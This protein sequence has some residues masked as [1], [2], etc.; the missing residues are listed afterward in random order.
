MAAYRPKAK[1]LLGIDISATAIKLIELSRR[2]SGYRVESHA[3]V[4][5]SAGAVVDG[6]VVD[7]EA[8]GNA[9]R[10]AARK[11]RTNNRYAAI[12]VAGSAAITRT[13]TLPQEL[14]DDEMEQQVLLE[15]DQHVPYPSDEVSVDFEVL[16]P[17][18]GEADMVDVL[19]VAARNDSINT[20]VS[21][22]EIAGLTPAVLDVE[23]YA[24]ENASVFLAHQMPN[25]GQDKTVA[26]IDVGATATTF[27]VLYDRKTIYSRE[28]TFGS[29]Q[30][31]EGIAGS[32][33]LSVEEA[34]SA[35]RMGS[36][37]AQTD[38]G[39]QPFMEDLL[40][41]IERSLQLFYS[42]N[43]QHSHIDQILL[44]GGCT[45]I[46]GID[47]AVAERVGVATVI[48]SPFENMSMAGR[49]RTSALKQEGPSLL[50]ACGLAL[51]SFD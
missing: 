29:Q 33:D 16:G 7:I 2:V 43:S 22:L 20:R 28:Q 12:A 35:S 31:A 46:G 30:L 10:R 14:S 11:A 5:L 51:R 9:I 39:Y 37:S 17:A 48:A 1:P 6:Q 15:A 34:E 18:A 25:Q 36:V 50:I 49:A 23:N 19:L 42:S 41:M 40:Q 3:T 27:T 32:Y 13:I 45:A 38:T 8:V 24:L 47:A 44:A 4:E 21:A 26:L